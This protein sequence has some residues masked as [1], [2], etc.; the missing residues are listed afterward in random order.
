MKNGKWIGGLACSLIGLY[1]LGLAIWMTLAGFSVLAT[2][3]LFFVSGSV[4]TL[5]IVLFCLVGADAS[6]AE[7]TG[8]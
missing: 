2:S 3:V 5:G 7:K 4:I 1:N 6:R 8:T